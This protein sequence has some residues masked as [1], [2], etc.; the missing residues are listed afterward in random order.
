MRKHLAWAS[1]TLAILIAACGT[2][3]TTHRAPIIVLVSLDAFRWDYL[4]RPGAVN[5]RALA[6]RGAHAERLVPAFP[7]KTYPNHYTLVTGLY[8]EHHGIVANNM[9][10]SVLG[11]FATGNDPAVR[12]GRWFG[13]EPIWVTAEK[14][15]VRSAVYFWPGDESEIG[16]VRPTWYVGYDHSVSR[17]DRVR[18]ALDWLA[19]PMDSAPRFITLYF[20]DVD[21]ASHA[22][23]PAGA[24]TDS[25]IVAVDSAV[26]ALV[27]GIVRLKMTDH[28]N[29]I[30]VSDHGMAATAPDRTVFLDDYVA[31][32][33]LDVIDW[34]P[35][36][37][38]MPKSAKE[39]YV[40]RR[41]KDANAHLTVYLKQDI[42]ARF[43]FNANP[44]ITPIVAIADEGWTI[45]TRARFAKAATA[46]DRGAHG[47]DNALP[48]MGAI[49]VGAG[50]AFRRGVTVPPF[51]NIHVYPLLAAILGVTPARVDGS[52]DS[53][54]ALLRR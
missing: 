4:Q 31:M 25:A 33:S 9:V 17:A 36:A 19:L 52:L 7:S 38:I 20:E 34:T 5:L 47:Y 8:T 13:G 1:A 10:D 2:T 39:R 45:T 6:A 51:Q 53:V 50:P 3:S 23:G 37:A 46:G 26:G 12:D 35:V 30:V 42:P 29:V 15:H 16:G 54:R 14:Q 28:V 32:D 44:R 43:H 22:V 24:C 18:R 27:D 11:K 48:S 49:F 41:L 21:A 40:Y